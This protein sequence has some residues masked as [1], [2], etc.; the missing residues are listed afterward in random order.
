MPLGIHRI[1]LHP[2][3]QE[4]EF[5]KF[6]TEELF[7]AV[8]TKIDIRIGQVNIRY[9][10][11]KAYDAE[12]GDGTWREYLWLVEVDQEAVDTF[13]VDLGEELRAKLDAFG[14][15]LYSSYGVVGTADHHTTTPNVVWF[16]DSDPDTSGW[17][18]EWHRREDR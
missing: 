10:L 17:V 4:E 18:G 14:A 9:L 12:N 7:P 3:A 1:V 15:R 8:E 16:S 6:M 2:E 13:P 11:A 5:E